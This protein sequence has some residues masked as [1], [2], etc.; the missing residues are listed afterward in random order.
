M[1]FRVHAT[2]ST[3]EHAARIVRRL[4]QEEGLTADYGS[5]EELREWWVQLWPD[6]AHLLRTLHTYVVIIIE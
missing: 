2:T 4:E 1:M 5:V 3:Q 6:A